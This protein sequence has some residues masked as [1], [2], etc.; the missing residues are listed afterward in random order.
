MKSR[1]HFLIVF[2]FGLKTL[3]ITLIL[4]LY[5]RSE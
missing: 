4:R 1:E 3:E 2:M 5:G